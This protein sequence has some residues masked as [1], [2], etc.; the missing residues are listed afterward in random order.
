MIGKDDI[1][2][3]WAVQ[4]KDNESA[5]PRVV[6][7]DGNALDEVAIADAADTCLLMCGRIN[8][9]ITA[10]LSMTARMA[11]LAGVAAAR[12]MEGD[13]ENLW[14]ELR[15]SPMRELFDPRTF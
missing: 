13:P 4:L 15:E 8:P 11:F 2:R 6:D 5:A 7:V 9:Q 14:D 1:M 10:V 12:G 3:A